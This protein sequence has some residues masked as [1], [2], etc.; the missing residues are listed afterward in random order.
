MFNWLKGYSPK[1][2]KKACQEF[3]H[4]LGRAAASGWV[5][6][7]RLLRGA[8]FATDE[9]KWITIHPNGKGYNNSGEK[10]KGTPLLIDDKT[11]TVVAGAGGKFNGQPL[12][13]MS[14]GDDNQD[15]P[16]AVHSLVTV[17]INAAAL[18]TNTTQLHALSASI[19]ENDAQG[20]VKW[21]KTVAPH[22]DTTGLNYLKPAEAVHFL[23][24]LELVHQAFPGVLSNLKG[25]TCITAKREQYNQK[26]M[27]Y[28][29]RCTQIEKRLR[30]NQKLK[31]QITADVQ[32]SFVPEI[33]DVL[34]SGNE[35][36]FKGLSYNSRLL[37]SIDSVK[38]QVALILG[39]RSL[40]QLSK[41]ER[42]QLVTI[43]SHA[44]TEVAM[45]DAVN[46]VLHNQ[47]LSLPQRPKDHT[48]LK[49]EGKKDLFGGASFH[50]PTQEIW[51]SQYWMGPNPQ[52]DLE[53]SY[54]AAIAN[55]F[56]TELDEDISV[57]AA[58]GAHEAAHCLDNAMRQEPNKYRSD[59]DPTIKGAYNQYTRN[60][61]K[62]KDGPYSSSKCC[63]FFAEM[64]AEALTSPKPSQQ[65]Q[66]MLKHAQKLYHQHLMKGHGYGS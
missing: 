4:Y 56:H 1:Q 33:Y 50:C 39:R 13:A 54:R 65:A 29:Q 48:V 28:Q 51:V 3:A 11:K 64:V 15:Q 16:N 14:E 42:H 52:K 41:T 30:A 9:A 43:L 21:L 19:T 57:I 23:R 40:K 62:L 32:D 5:A 46:F 45:A 63:E 60:I 8:P 22:V 36:D 53:Q 35:A 2:I 27:E 10:I 17:P 31:A 25:I 34:K 24:G 26:L 38:A 18:A 12:S 58:L 66:A 6:A 49:R 59:S 55:G 61:A 20:R 37:L 44:A 47:G 7:D